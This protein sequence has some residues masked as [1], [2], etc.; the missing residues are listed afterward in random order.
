MARALPE[1]LLPFDYLRLWGRGGFRRVGDGA[2]GTRPSLCLLARCSFGDALEHNSIDKFLDVRFWRAMAGVGDPAPDTLSDVPSPD[3]LRRVFLVQPTHAAPKPLDIS[4]SQFLSTGKQS[5]AKKSYTL[6]YR[7]NDRFPSMELQAKAVEK[8]LD[9]APHLREATLFIVE[10]QKVVA[11]PHVARDS[12]CFLQIMVQRIE[13]RG[14]RGITSLTGCL[15]TDLAFV[16][17]EPYR[18]GPVLA[19]WPVHHGSFSIVS[20]PKGLWMLGL[21]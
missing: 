20:R 8:S 21:C 17:S 13:V 19:L 18:V 9:F 7:K 3:A 14:D 4:L 10:N 2:V 12:Q 6:P 11:V 15:K 16:Y 1:N 5:K